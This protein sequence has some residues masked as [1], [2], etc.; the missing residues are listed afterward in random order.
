MSVISFRNGSKRINA[1]K[2]YRKK[3]AYELHL[4]LQSKYP[5]K[6]NRIKMNVTNNVNSEN[7]EMK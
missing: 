5:V 6:L 2:K 3:S 4:H 7:N 1:N